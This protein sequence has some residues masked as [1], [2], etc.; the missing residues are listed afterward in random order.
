MSVVAEAI[1]RHLLAGTV[2]PL[3]LPVCLWIPR[4]GEPVFDVV[5]LADHVEVRPVRRRKGRRRSVSARAPAPVLALPNQRWN[6][7][8]VHD[9]MATGRRFRLM[10]TV[11]DAKRECLP[12]VLDMS[13]LGKRVAREL[14]GL[15][16]ERGTSKMIISDNGT[17]LT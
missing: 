8:F 11:N 10:S 14:G 4:F 13:I 3:D 7:D 12:A 9:Q 2:P 1:D 5:C 15:V 16:I 17:E 6:L